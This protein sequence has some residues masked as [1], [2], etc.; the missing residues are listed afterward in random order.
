MLN[1]S[2]AFLLRAAQSFS[3]A[4]DSFLRS[5]AAACEFGPHMQEGAPPLE[6]AYPRPHVTSRTEA[7][8][9]VSKRGGW[10][11]HSH[12][13]PLVNYSPACLPL[14]PFE[15]TAEQAAY[16]CLFLNKEKKKSAA[17]VGGCIHMSITRA[18]QAGS[19]APL[20]T[21][22]LFHFTLE[23]RTKDIR[24]ATLAKPK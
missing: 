22:H 14:W 23:E 20:T 12:M 13:T 5:L 21:S 24:V 8:N 9:Q 19:A 7:R 3:P 4:E 16:L 11:N 2:V 1:T 15:P 17:T 6:S 18:L 10:L